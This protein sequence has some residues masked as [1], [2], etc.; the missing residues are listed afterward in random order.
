MKR[1]IEFND[2]LAQ[3]PKRGA[4]DLHLSVG[5]YPTFR[6]NNELV[7]YQEYGVINQSGVED[8]ISSFVSEELLQK[9]KL[10]KEFEFS[11][12]FQNQSR[13]RVFIFY[14]QGSMSA[15][16]RFIPLNIPKFNELGLDRINELIN[17]SSGLI[18]FSG[19][20]GS[21][22]TTSAA[23]LLNEINH[24]H[25]KHIVTIEDPIEYLFIEDKS[26]IDQRQ[27]GRDTGSISNALDSLTHTD[28]DV[29]FVDEL[30]DRE[31][32][33]GAIKASK[34]GYLVISTLYAV[35][36]ANALDEIINHFPDDE[37]DYIR[38]EL[39]HVL[40]A[41][42]SQRLVRRLGGGRVLA[43]ETMFVNQPIRN[44][45]HEN[46][47]HQVMSAIQTGKQSKMMTLDSHLAELVKAK[48][49]SSETGSNTAID[50]ENFSSEIKR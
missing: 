42:V 15:S 1:S 16:F 48:L 35:D 32:I 36:S 43:Y 44:M 13:F 38:R 3:M 21:G 26:I 33:W 17:V 11:F 50:Y 9:M 4:S 7:L 28:A 41:I 31:S 30:R 24:V 34:M 5:R 47:E 45:I 20:A 25:A 10:R 18:L 29:V 27:V 12:T 19:P 46:K 40:T 39:S 23:S 37:R 6:I 8:L 2:L 22:K 14:Q 49:I